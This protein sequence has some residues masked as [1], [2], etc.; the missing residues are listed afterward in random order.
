MLEIVNHLSLRENVYAMHA[1]KLLVENKKNCPVYD[2]LRF[3]Y[4]DIFNDELYCG[5]DIIQKL[6]IQVIIKLQNV[7]VSI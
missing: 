4:C 7:Y 2:N 3:Q 6:L 1:C 5:S